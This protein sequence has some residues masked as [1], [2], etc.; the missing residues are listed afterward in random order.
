[1]APDQTKAPVFTSSDF[2]LDTVYCITGQIVISQQLGILDLHDTVAKRWIAFFSG[3]AWLRML[4]SMR[5]ET[6]LGPRLLPIL[7][8]IKDTAAFF[9]ITTVCV[10]ALAHAYYQM[11]LR[12]DDPFPIYASLLQTFRLG[13]MGDFNLFELEG[14][15]V[16]YDR[17]IDGESERCS[18]V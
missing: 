6:W 3:M 17:I 18:A 14:K 2:V 16:E 8:A 11:S 5:G 7:A 12:D 15:D 9:F 4:Y 10:L 13:I 1:M